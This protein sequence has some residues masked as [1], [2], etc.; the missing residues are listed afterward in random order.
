MENI[1]LHTINIHTYTRGRVCHGADGGGNRGDVTLPFSHGSE[2]MVFHMS[3][4]NIIQDFTHST[5]Q[6]LV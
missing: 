4:A 2:S 1:F 5:L 3:T 6:W